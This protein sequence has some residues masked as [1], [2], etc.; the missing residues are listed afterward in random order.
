MAGSEQAATGGATAPPVALRVRRLSKGFPG[1]QAL[2]HVDLEV[3]AGEV[4]GLVGENGAGKST[5][6]KIV[7]GAYKPDSGL[8]AAFGEE[9]RY[10]D[11][12]AH[13]AAGIAAIYQE[14]NTVPEMSAAANVFLGRWPQRARIVSRPSLR[15]RFRE[16]AGQLGVDI[17]PTTTAR[18]LSVAHQQQLEIM[19]ALD[20]SHRILI[21]DEPT[22]ALGPREREGLYESVRWVKESGVAVI[23]ISHDLEEV[24]ELCDRVTVMREGSCVATRPVREWS[25]QTLV[26]AMLGR[27]VLE[28]PPRT[29][30]VHEEA[31]RVEGLNIPGLLDDVSFS[32]GHGE[33]LGVAGLIGSGRTELLRALAGDDPSARGQLFVDGSEVPWP[34]SVR[35]ALD[36]GIALAPEDR[37]TAGLVLSLS[38]AV[39]V[40]LSD[41]SQV[42]VGPL[43]RRPRVAERASEVMGGLAFDPDRLGVQAA[44][45]SGGNQQKLVVGKWLHR[46]PKILLMDEPTRGIDVGAKAEMLSVVTELADRG[47]AV[48]FVSAELEEVLSVADRILVLVQGRARATLD[49]HESSMERIL[50]VVFGL[51]DAL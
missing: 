12:R 23:Y 32:L 35:R 11:P 26:A 3:R 18:V 14:P 51:E 9:L 31:L 20:S 38:G 37:R 6:I 29:E 24:L 43:V 19:R 46:V 15:R 48:I 47:M 40:V 36:L 44:T 1:V 34:R 10:G 39:N 8:V 41:P 45:L 7:T 49:R 28:P 2:D 17:E 50:S 27:V 21:M 16:L 25:P 33:I 5:L 13:A 42:S 4:H 30:R 22:S